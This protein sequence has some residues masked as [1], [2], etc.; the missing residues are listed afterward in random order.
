MLVV[1][2]EKINN[3]NVA[4]ET[5]NKVDDCIRIK[6]FSELPNNSEVEV[7]VVY[8]ESST[9]N[10]CIDYHI[11][12]DGYACVLSYLVILPQEDLPNVNNLEVELIFISADLKNFVSEGFSIKPA[13]PIE[14]VTKLWSSI[15]EDFKVYSGEQD[16]TPITT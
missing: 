1:E 3:C 10:L 16:Y 6:L 2:V 14:E 13:I 5:I 11:R 7:N 9:N 12:M 8:T 4:Q 15:V